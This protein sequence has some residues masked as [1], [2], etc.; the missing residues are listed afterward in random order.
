MH[1]FADA[2][3][4]IGRQVV[5]ARLQWWRVVLSVRMQKSAN[6]SMDSDALLLHCHARQMPRSNRWFPAISGL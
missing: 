1:D 2:A 3:F 4:G 5:G 6:C